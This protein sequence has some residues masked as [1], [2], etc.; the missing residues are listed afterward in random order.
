MNHV[1]KLLHNRYVSNALPLALLIVIVLAFQ[2][3]SG[4]K[5]LTSTNMS[6]I[7]EQSVIVAVCA[8]GIA[9]IYTTGNIDMSVGSIIMLSG[10][11]AGKVWLATDSI[12]LMFIVDFAVGALMLY[13]NNVLS[14]VLGLRTVICAILMMNI[15]NAIGAEILGADT[16]SIYR[17]VKGIASSN[18]R[19]IIFIALVILCITVFHFTK[20]G[21]SLRLVGGND[22][23][24]A[25]A[26]INRKKV[27]SYGYVVAALCVGIACTF[28]LIRTGNISST[29]SSMGTDLMLATVLGGMSIFGGH[30]SNAYSGIIGA[31]TVTVLNNGLLMLGVSNTI[32]QGVRGV[33]FLVI[34]YMNSDH[35]DT[36]PSRNQFE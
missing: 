26:G 36:L 15:Y 16:I 13:L 24:A 21:R 4:G 27:I 28:T 1:K 34:V 31:F 2:I 17:Y 6:T 23:C 35:P 32:I 25:T 8:I 12:V 14:A 10:V 22:K 33:L 11:I 9:F 3:L 30:K 19:L 18:I 5:F 29:A 20:L 7:F